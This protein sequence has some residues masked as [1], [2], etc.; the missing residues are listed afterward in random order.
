MVMV[1]TSPLLIHALSLHT[2]TV[3]CSPFLEVVESHCLQIL[4]GLFSD[5]Y[6][7]IISY[8]ILSFSP[9]PEHSLF[10]I[11]LVTFSFFFPVMSLD[12]IVSC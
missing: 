2:H 7:I 11:R 12:A 10:Y 6:S 5:V 3:F 9:G 1:I 8:T 4:K